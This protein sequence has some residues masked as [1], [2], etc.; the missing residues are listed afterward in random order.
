MLLLFLEQARPGDVHVLCG[1]PGDRGYH[2]GD[3]CP[4]ESPI[5]SFFLAV[6]LERSFVN[7]DQILT[8]D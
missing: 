4:R 8:N 3:P 2:V 1:R 5:H 6:V 7:C